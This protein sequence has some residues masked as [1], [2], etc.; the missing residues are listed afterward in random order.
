M[1]LLID[2]LRGDPCIVC[3]E[4]H[5]IKYSNDPSFQKCINCNLIFQSNIPTDQE[6]K[7]IYS[8]YLSSIHINNELPKLRIEAYKEDIKFL[9][10]SMLN[11]N[12]SASSIKSI[13]DYGASGGAFLDTL[14]NSLSIDNQLYGW[15]FGVES[16]KALKKKK[17]YKTLEDVDHG[18]DLLVLRGVIE[19]LPKPIETINQLL[20]KLDP[21]IV[22]I[23]ATPN[24]DSIC[25]HLFKESWNQHEPN[26]HL[27]HFNSYH[28]SV[29]FGRK[30]YSLI[31][32]NHQYIDTPYCNLSSD[33]KKIIQKINNSSVS[34]NSPPF[35]DN[36]ISAAFLKHCYL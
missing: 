16:Q 19:H 33:S 23:S 20:D 5:F 4:N 36:M 17:Y 32:L 25:S 21:K 13:F 2:I 18:V 12:Q 34:T 28:L 35:F 24:G 3:G 15:D 9:K 29:I 30:N 22:L 6:L 27:Y 10:A 31:N 11:I 26:L 14:K 1:H 7:Y 8:N